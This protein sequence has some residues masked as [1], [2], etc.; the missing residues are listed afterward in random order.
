MKSKSFKILLAILS[1][2]LVLRLFKLDQL[3]YFSMDEAYVAFR[4]W[5][6]FTLKRPFLIGAAGPLQFH[7]PPYYFYL[8]A[9][10]LA[11]FK[12]NPVGWGFWS[13]LIGTATIYL[14]FKLTKK[15]IN[16]NTAIIASL[17]Y[18]TSFTAVFFDRHYWPLN[19]NPFYTLITLLLLLKLNKKSIYSYLILAA[20]LVLATSSD[21][22]NLT[23]VILTLTYLFKV[24][25]KLKP[26]FIKSFFTTSFVLFFSPLLL[27]DLRHHWQNLASLTSFFQKT[28]AH[29]FQLNN[30]INALLLIPRSLVRFWYSPQTDIAK[31]HAYC[32]LFSHQRQQNLSIFLVLLSFFILFIFFKKNHNSKNKLLLTSSLLIML[33]FFGISL[34]AFLGYPIFDHYLSGLLPIF[35]LVTAVFISSLPDKLKPLVVVLFISLN[36]SQIY[37]ANNPYGLAFKQQLV[38]WAITNLQDQDYALHSISKCH[39]ENGLRYLFELTDNPPKQSFMDPNFAWLYKKPPLV[40]TPDLKLLVTDKPLNTDLSII[41]HQ[42]FGAINAYLLTNPS[43]SRPSHK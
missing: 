39:K 33:Y 11:P 15:A 34:Y 23:L 18:T 9:L 17:L 14:L 4:G 12:F 31:L 21:P 41:S 30:F 38:D 3:F 10:L 24:K 35:A 25:T 27:F 36:L 16:Q 26:K 6:L 40:T 37:K 7:L 42:S 8:S 43:L 1:L 13:A 29:Q 20:T 5:G 2:G 32:D 22:S 19:L 28:A